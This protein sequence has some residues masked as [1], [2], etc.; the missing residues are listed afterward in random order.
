VLQHLE[1]GHDVELVVA[2]RQIGAGER[3]ELEIR[4]AAPLPLRVERGVVEVDAHHAARAEPLRKPL[5]QH[6][7]ATADVE[8]GPGRGLVPELVERRFEAGH[9]PPYDRVLRA[10][11]VVGVAGRYRLGDRI[12]HSFRT[13]RSSPGS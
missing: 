1:R 11:L 10:V 7:L 5:G 4:P 12:G 6:P 2:E 9:E 3:A 13:S 8:R